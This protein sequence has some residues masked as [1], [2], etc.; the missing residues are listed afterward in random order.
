M[1]ATSMTPPA[2][3]LERLIENLPAGFDTMRAEARAEGYR[4]VET[5]ATDWEA[6]MTRFDREGEVLLAALLDG[7]LA[8]I[9]GLTID[10]VTP[11]AMRMRRFYIRAPFRR[12]GI[13]R[14]L[15]TALLEQ[16]I[17]TGRGLI[18]VNAAAGSASFWESLGF[19]PDMRDGHTHVLVRQPNEHRDGDAFGLA[20]GIDCQH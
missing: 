14:Q 20:S 19:A 4:F 6:R 10:P 5:L 8:G 16:P 1:Q 13:G 12:S 2:L 11:G 7:T 3:R 9:G 15:A 18:A 17:R